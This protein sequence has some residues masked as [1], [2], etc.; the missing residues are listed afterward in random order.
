MTIK[1]RIRDLLRTRGYD[2][3][4]FPSPDFDEHFLATYNTVKPYT[5]TSPERVFAVVEATRYAVHNGIPGSFVECGVWRGGSMM[6]VA[7][8]LQDLDTTDRELYLF[9]TFE[10]M[11]KPT[12]ADRRHDGE[13]ADALLARERK[14]V[15][16]STWCVAD[17]ADVAANMA[18]T[19]YP[20]ERVHLIRG[21]VED[22]VPDAAPETIAVLRLDTDW[23]ESTKHELEHL[24]PR[25]SP[26]GV[27]IIDDYGWWQGARTAVDGYLA[28]TGVPL[29]L[30][31]V[32]YT[33]RV[34]VV[35]GLPTPSS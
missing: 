20:A 25:V 29:L 30:Q 26:G 21:K 35:P 6:A 19:G 10:G 9:D 17:Q 4:A 5:L 12:A 13:S 16:D 15:A 34:A 14:D 27:L 22:T 28:E 1:S 7:D 3:V 24:F 32:D 11:A 31:R 2:I 33:A 8:T 18:R 23:Y